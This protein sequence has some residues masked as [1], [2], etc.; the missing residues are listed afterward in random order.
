VEERD[1]ELPD[2]VLQIVM[3]RYD[4]RHGH[5]EVAAPLAPEQVEQAVV[6]LRHEDRHPLAPARLDEPEVEAAYT[7]LVNNT[8][9]ALSNLAALTT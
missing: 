8:D 5:L 2:V 3:I 1:P 9:A 4:H 7:S 6:G